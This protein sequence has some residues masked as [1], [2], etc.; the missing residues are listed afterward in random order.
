VCAT[1]MMML[2]LMLLLLRGRCVVGDSDEVC[3]E[4]RR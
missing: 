2:L 4:R 1:A 3:A